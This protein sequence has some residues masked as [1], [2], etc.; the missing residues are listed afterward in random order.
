MLK[1]KHF[2]Q[3]EVGCD[4]PEPVSWPRRTYYPNGV[5]VVHIEDDRLGEEVVALKGYRPAHS[6]RS[7]YRQ[8]NN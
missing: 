8:P 6:R 3:P 4:Q 1:S 5:L 7:R 2:P